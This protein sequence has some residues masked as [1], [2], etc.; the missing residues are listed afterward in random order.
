MFR[1]LFSVPI[2]TVL[3]VF[4]TIGCTRRGDTSATGERSELRV[5]GGEIALG[6]ALREAR[7]NFTVD[8]K[9]IHPALVYEFVGWLSD[10]GPIATAV[11]LITAQKSNKYYGLQVRVRKGEIEC[12]VQP[13][14]PCGLIGGSPVDRETFGYRRLGVLA[15]GT[16][17]LETAYWGGG[18]GIFEDVLFVR[19]GIERTLDYEGKPCERLVMKALSVVGLGDRDD[20]EVRVLSDR[21]ILGRSKYRDKE[22]V[23]RLD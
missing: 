6:K 16:S 18:S 20:G 14:I 17:V 4:A 1:N 3:V 11:N 7:E 19:F 23:L 12:D 8:G 13:L 15:D 5:E 10:P 22:I 21:V 9:P 2:L